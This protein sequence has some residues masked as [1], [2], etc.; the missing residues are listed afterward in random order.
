MSE[1]KTPGVYI[2]EGSVFPPSVAEA[3]TASAIFI[4]Y[5]EKVVENGTDLLQTP[6]QIRSLPEY[7]FFF[8]GAPDTTRRFCFLKHQRKRTASFVCLRVCA[9]DR[10]S[11]KTEI[12]SYWSMNIWSN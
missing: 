3:E 4:G 7:Q 6:K 2:E 11:E 10:L 8:G 1:Y 12:S 9:G 5:T